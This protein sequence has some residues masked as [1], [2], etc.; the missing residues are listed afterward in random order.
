MDWKYILVKK[1]I[2]AHAISRLSRKLRVTLEECSLLRISKQLLPVVVHQY[3]NN[4]NMLNIT[5]LYSCD[6]E[7]FEQ[8]NNN[9][10]F[11][12]ITK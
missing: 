7:K 11:I 9:I 1:I 3:L 2:D 4:N 10:L 12:R 6:N 5:I 8:N